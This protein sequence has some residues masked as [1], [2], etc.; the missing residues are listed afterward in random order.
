MTT[1]DE[2][3]RVPLFE[4]LTDEQLREVLEEGSEELVPAGEVGGREGEPVEHLYVIL[5]GEFRWS[6]KVDGGEVV[7]NTYGSGEFF[8]EVPL[9][10]GKPFLATWRAL[11]DSRVFALPNETFRRMLATNPSFSNAILEML[12]QR[13]QV[14][15]SVAQQRERLGS[16]GTLAAGLAHELNNPAS[17][18]RRAAGRLRESSE[19]L[20][21][22][23]M[24]L[25]R[26]AARGEIDPAQLDALERIVRET[27][28]RDK[29][30][31][32][33]LDTLKRSEREEEVG[34]WLEDRGVEEAWDLSPTFV[35][36]GLD[37]ADLEFVEGAVPPG[38]LADTLRYLE[39]A[40]GVE[41]LVDEVEESSTRIS[42]L[43]ATMEGYS[44]M[45]QAPTQEV[46]VN[47]GL[48]NTLAILRYKLEGIEVQ[49]DYDESLPRITA[50]G[51]ELNQVWTNLIDNAA[52][53]VADG[54]K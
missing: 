10:L 30:P 43:I 42:K 9:L 5:E 46:D 29:A 22:V 3:R 53:A 35:G 51:N 36:A 39:A 16:L 52:D 31:A 6:K 34:L 19:N 33:I 24:R 13:I 38:A 48:D 41:G 21:F 44:Y 47:Q 7:M 12:A 28:G 4:G 11:A 1:L 2:L 23:G 32:P 15:Y 20:R 18:S 45:D 25:A 27:L 40:L 54:D 17:A 49:R 26:A 8:A 50:H 14:L 37:I